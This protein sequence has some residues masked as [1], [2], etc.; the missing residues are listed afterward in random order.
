[1][2]YKIMG[3]PKHGSSEVKCIREESLREIGKP[4]LEKREFWEKVRKFRG[5]HSNR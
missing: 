4:K 1:M 3:M 2:K 5:I